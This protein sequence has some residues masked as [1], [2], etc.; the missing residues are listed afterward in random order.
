MQRTTPQRPAPFAVAGLARGH[1]QAQSASALNHPNIV[2]IYDID[3]VD[4]VTFI[5]MEFVD[6]RSLEAVIAEARL[7]IAQALDYAVQAAGA[8]AAAHQA[9]IVHRDVKPANILVTRERTGK[10]ARLWSR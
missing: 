6:G 3:S 8:L 2:H 9:G 4:A 10:G 1:R 5:V 7:P